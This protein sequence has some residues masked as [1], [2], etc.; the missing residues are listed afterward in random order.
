M[1]NFQ[2]TPEMLKL[3]V[4]LRCQCASNTFIE[5]K[6]VRKVPALVAGTPEPVFVQFPAF[7]C[8]NCGSI[9]DGFASMEDDV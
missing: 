8:V 3:S 5:A 1:Q 2:V 4:S 6:K 7:M 9:H